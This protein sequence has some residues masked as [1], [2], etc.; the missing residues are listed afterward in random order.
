M[1]I[2]VICPSCGKNGTLPETMRGH[3]IKCPGCHQPFVVSAANA[4]TQ[5]LTGLHA[6]M[7]EDDDDQPYDVRPLRRASTHQA[8]AATSQA[9][10]TTLFVGLGIGAALSVVLAVVAL[11]M[12]QKPDAKPDRVVDA[13]ATVT[14]ADPLK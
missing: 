10:P 7:T 2:P 13:H 11:L 4:G 3:R 12:L 9:T 1:R 5:S 14:P 6:A 8:R